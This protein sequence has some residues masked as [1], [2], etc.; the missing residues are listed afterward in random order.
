MK[1]TRGQS[2]PLPPVR[3]LAAV[4]H[5]GIVAMVRLGKIEEAIDSLR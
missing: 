5:P 1:F 2:S 3:A 4:E